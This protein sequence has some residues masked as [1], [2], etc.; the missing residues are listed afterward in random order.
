MAWSTADLLRC[1]AGAVP[2]SLDGYFCVQRAQAFRRSFAGAEFAPSR[3]CLQE[4]VTRDPLYAEAWAMLGWIDVMGSNFGYTDAPFSEVSDR[5]L[6]YA[7]RAYRLE[8]DN[9]RALTVM[10]VVHHD[11]GDVAEGERFVRESLARNPH[12]PSVLIRPGW[13]LTIR[14]AF[15]EGLP[16]VDQA[17]ARSAN[18]PGWYYLPYALD[19]F[20]A[21]DGPGIVKVGSA[22][23]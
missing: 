13:R 16:Y 20:M 7:T 21:G 19:R 17:I 4:A 1:A 11:R 12:D 3:A 9:P 10:S 23:L 18:P 22:G 14:G 6:Q 8:P 5:A 15:D 2:A